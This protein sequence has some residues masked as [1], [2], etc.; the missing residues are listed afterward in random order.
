MR[1]PSTEAMR[2]RPS[3]IRLRGQA[4]LMRMKPSPGEPYMVPLFTVTRASAASLSV[5]SS[6]VMPRLRQSTHTRYVPSS[7]VTRS[8]GSL[9]AKNRHSSV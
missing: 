5:S 1:Q 2:P 9:S 3:I 8:R 6:D 7:G 4:M